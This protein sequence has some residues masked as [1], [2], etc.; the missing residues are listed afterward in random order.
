M[1]PILYDSDETAFTSNGLGRLRDCTSCTVTEERNGIYECDF[2]YP[3]NGQNY[4]RIQ[5]GRIIAV[6]HEDSDDVQ[7][8]DIVSRS[9]PISGIVTFHAVHISYRQSKIVVSGTG[10][11][12]LAAA[13]TML[14]NAAPTNP[15]TY[16]TDKEGSGYLAA[17]DGVPRSV[18]SML[19]GVDGSILD[20]YGGEYQYNKFV[21]SL[22]S[23][24]GSERNATIRY[25]INLLDYTDD[26]DYADAYTAC[27]PYWTGSNTVVKGGLVRSGVTSYN[28]REE[29]APLDLTDKFENQP[30]AAQLQAA[31]L[32]YM[33]SNQTYLPSQ[34]INI[35]FIRLQDTQEYAEYAALF[36]CKLCD[37]V[38]VVFPR[39]GMDGRFKIVKTVYN[40][41][42]ER[43]E[44]ME[45]GNLPISLSQAL[46]LSK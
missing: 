9:R 40:V 12:T 34:S 33:Q 13:F 5:L 22:L 16:E 24:R 8:F 15:F 44:E 43:Y 10:I 20:T 37:T 27:V 1:I 11:S 46:G 4:E 30:T 2:D 42:L 35:N 7:P 21:V 38:R 23:A 36:N 29:A 25:G 3:I 18:K 26:M 32:T 39:Y 19:G 6:E 14:N 31:A 45:L 41:L 17:A 28:G